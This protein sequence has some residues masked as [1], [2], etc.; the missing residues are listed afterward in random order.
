MQLKLP[1]KLARVLALLLP[2]LAV[3]AAACG[4]QS[5]APPTAT[6]ACDAY[7][8]AICA[9]L[10]QCNPI[11]LQSLFGSTDA[12]VASLTPECAW[13]YSVPGASV[14]P[15]WVEAC[16]G[17][18]GQQSCAEAAAKT[19]AACQPPPGTLANGQACASDQQC[20]GGECNLI[21]PA[22]ATNVACGLCA[23]AP[24]FAGCRVSSDCPGDQRCTGAFDFPDGGVQEGTCIEPL[25]LGASCSGPVCQAGLACNLDSSQNMVCAPLATEGQACN[26]PTTAGCPPDLVCAKGTCEKP[27][28]VALGGVCVSGGAQVCVAGDCVADGTCAPHAAVGEEH[29]A[30]PRGPRARPRR[31]AWAGSARA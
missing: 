31:P 27:Q 15:A 17:A 28:Y 2:G 6:S 30:S 26:S 10:A 11:D 9:Q 19:P 16:A 3:A 4:G 22:T 21:A 13:T 25:G 8:R 29:A 12:C 14:T 18:I 20:A 23:D 5:S 24:T 1:V 7:T